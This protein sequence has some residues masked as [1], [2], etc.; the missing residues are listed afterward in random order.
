MFPS[1]GAALLA[2]DPAAFAALN[3][4]LSRA[5]S[6][7][8]SPS[9]AAGADQA[10]AGHLAREPSAVAGQVMAG[11]RTNAAAFASFGGLLAATMAHPLL[12]LTA[13]L[14]V[15]AGML[16]AVD[17]L[18]WRARQV[19]AHALYMV[20][21]YGPLPRVP[22]HRGAT[23][24]RQQPSPTRR[25]LFAGKRPVAAATDDAVASAA[26]QQQLRHDPVPGVTAPPFLPEPA[27]AVSDLRRGVLGKV[28]DTVAGTETAVLPAALL[29]GAHAGADGHAHAPAG[30][31]EGRGAK[32]YAREGHGMGGILQTLLH[33]A[34]AAGADG[35]HDR[36]DARIH[37]QD[38][39]TATS[40]L[41]LGAKVASL[42]QG[43]H[44]TVPE[45]H[46]AGYIKG[47]DVEPR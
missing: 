15:P 41:G 42:F 35:A 39:A 47:R 34:A 33:P 1:A 27:V 11:P 22:A 8:S 46:S 19:V 36:G 16:A 45:M 4:A 37:D 43:S 14:V 26:A 28:A 25:T 29:S 38:R 2:A 6:A 40:H 12:L 31:A 44:T 23:P 7:A 13:V 17:T 24:V 18:V 10:L 21:G 30:A 3:Q 5:T 32:V 9:A 20:R